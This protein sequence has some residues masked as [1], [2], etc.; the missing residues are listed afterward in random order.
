[1]QSCQRRQI[2]VVDDLA[3][4]LFMLQTFLEAE[5]YDVDIA[6]NGSLALD[7]IEASPPDLMLL[8][9]MMPE[10]DGIE[11]TQHIRSNHKL[12]LFPI[13][14]ISAYDKDS[15]L[16]GLDIGADDFIPKPINFNELVAKISAFLN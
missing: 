13:L 5:G 1:M 8:D 3:D 2:L 11:V 7:K 4:N 6:S 16:E 9:I 10:M 14:L 15:L 12:P